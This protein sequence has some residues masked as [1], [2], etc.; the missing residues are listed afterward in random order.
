MNNKQE[1]SISKTEPKANHKKEK[2]A[3]GGAIISFGFLLLSAAWNYFGTNPR[4]LYLPALGICLFIMYGT[5]IYVRSELAKRQ[6]PKSAETREA[7]PAQPKASPSPPLIRNEAVPRA[8]KPRHKP[9]AKG[10]KSPLISLSDGQRFVLKRK[11]GAYAGN[12]VQLVLVGSNPSA[13]IVFEQLIDVFKDSGWKIQTARIGM[14]GIVGAN[15]PDG[16]YMTSRNM[17]SPV[18]ASVFSIFSGVGIDLPL[19]P[20]AF[21]GPESMVGSPD[22]VIVLH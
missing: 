7:Q 9:S 10:L 15:F 5:H 21:M 20:N 22:L 4:I 8:E 19:T 17:A 12:T 11:L 2:I 3:G 13:G 1:E 6:A 18:I 16:P 14:V